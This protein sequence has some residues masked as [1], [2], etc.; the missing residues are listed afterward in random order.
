MQKDDGLYESVSEDKNL[1]MNSV[2]KGMEQTWEQD[3]ACYSRQKE[4]QCKIPGKN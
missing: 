1:K 4:K 3:K 2:I